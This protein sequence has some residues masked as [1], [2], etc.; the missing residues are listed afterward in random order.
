[1]VDAISIK[2]AG[3]DR[4]FHF[5]NYALIE[6]GNILQCD[7]INAHVELINLAGENLLSGMAALLFSGFR[8]YECSQFILKPTITIQQVASE[9]AICNMDDFTP[10]WE[11]F[12]K[13]TGITEFLEAQAVKEVEQPVKKKKTHSV[14]S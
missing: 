8:G 11:N 14:A 4:I 2:F 9:L 12:K 6:L 1:M 5:N 7:P 3:Q 13:V 10:I